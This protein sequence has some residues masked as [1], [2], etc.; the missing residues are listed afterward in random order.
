MRPW[1]LSLSGHA[2]ALTSRAVF[3]TCGSSML[4]NFCGALFAL[5]LLAASGEAQCAV[6]ARGVRPQL[7]T[8]AQI[9]Y[10]AYADAYEHARVLQRAVDQ[11]VADPSDDAN[12]QLEMLRQAWLD[13]HVSYGS[14]EV[15]G[16]YEG[17][18]DFGKRADGSQGPEL[19]LNA[20]PLNESYI[21]A[22]IADDVPITREL[23][24]D[25]NARDDE[26]DVTTGYHAIEYLLWGPD[27]NANGAG[28][29]SPRDFL[30][31]GAASRRR[32]YLKVATDLLVEHPAIN[33][34]LKRQIAQSEA[35]AQALDRPFD[36]TLSTPPGSPE[37]AKVEALITSLQTQTRLFKQAGAALGVRPQHRHGWMP[38]LGAIRPWQSPTRMRSQDRCRICTWLI[39]ENSRSAIASSTPTG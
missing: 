5:S 24:I 25:R 10:R 33:E 20:W 14:T 26:A 31:D 21:D 30:G 32:Q 12:E 15:F 22:V 6:D 9:A 38:S 23:L 36:R 37:R 39:F 16:F 28:Q 13:A 7:E 34:L 35:L 2:S 11:F 1:Q 17:P 4:R 29:R 18:I 27:R 8:Y 19:L 3:N